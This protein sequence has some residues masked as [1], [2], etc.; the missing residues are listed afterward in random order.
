MFVVALAAV[1]NAQAYTPE[2][3]PFGVNAHQAPDDVLDLAADAGI[4]WVRFD[5]NWWQFEPADGVYDWT[6]ADRFMA[7]ADANDLQVF[8]TIAYTPTWAGTPGCDDLAIDEN[9]WCRNSVPATSD[10]TDFVTAAVDRYGSQVKAWGMWNEPNLSHFF[11]GTRQQYVNDILIPG[12]DAVHAAC[13]DCKVLGPELAHL[14]GA[15]WDS[16]AG[17]CIFGECVFNGWEVSL[18]AILDDAGP[19]IDII[20]HHKYTDPADRFWAETLDGEWLVV[21]FMHGIREIT[22]THAPGKP[23]WITEMGWETTP[24]GEHSPSYAGDQLYEAYAILDEVKD[25]TWNGTDDGPWPELQRMFWYDVMDDPVVH[26]WGQYTWGLVDANHVPKETYWS[27]QA[28]TGDLGGCD[29]LDT[30]PGTE[31]GDTEPGDTNPDP[32]TEGDPTVPGVEDEED[33]DP[34]EAPT[35]DA[36]TPAGCGCGTSGGPAAWWP[37]LALVLL[38]HRTRRA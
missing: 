31:P 32:D 37:L 20:S 34:V 1:L 9:A 17:N 26:P 21:Q 8:V 23:V 16:E 5:M 19:W 7:T 3:C 25:G 35:S 29:D 13:A 6:V 12:S 33:G 14:R 4:K 10:W 18:A 36:A 2:E 28:V 15:N 22:D 30:E 24:G 11:L 38:R 27:Y